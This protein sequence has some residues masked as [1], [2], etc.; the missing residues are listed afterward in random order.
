MS[1]GCG[2]HGGRCGDPCDCG[3]ARGNPCETCCS[4]SNAGTNPPG[5]DALD[6]GSS[7]YAA[8]L[9]RMRDRLS[10]ADLPAL[11][12]L[13]ARRIDEAVDPAMALVDGWA[14][15]GHVLDFYNE[16]FVNE[17]YLRTCTERRSVVE[18]ARLV[19]Y[20]P[21]PG[22]AA[23]IYL[24]FTL[25]D[26]DK[27]AVLEVPAGTRVYSQPGP[28]ETMQPFETV[29]AL[30]GRPRWSEIHPR[31]TEPQQLDLADI[32]LA[33]EDPDNEPV[34][35][36]V[37][38]ELYLKGIATGL[39]KG[40][41]LLL[42]I[43][44]LPFLEIISAIETFPGEGCTRIALRL[45]PELPDVQGDAEINDDRLEA[46]IR[47]PSINAAS[48][49]RIQVEPDELF[50]NRSY[51]AYG[52]LG[53]AYPALAANLGPA[54][55]GAT[56]GGPTG[57][58][59]VSAMRIKAAIHGHNAPQIPDVNDRGIL[60]GYREWNVRGVGAVNGPQLIEIDDIV[61]ENDDGIDDNLETWRRTIALDAVYDGIL[62][63]S[64]VV[65][66]Q[67]G[68]SL[69]RGHVAERT[70]VVERVRTVSRMQFNL[71][72]RVTV[73]TLDRAWAE[74]GPEES[75]GSFRE[76]TVY[77]QAEPVDLVE[78]PIEETVGTQEGHPWL[79]LD[80][81]YEGL[82]PGRRVIV[83]GE[84]ADLD[85]ITGVMVAELMLVARAEHGTRAQVSGQPVGNAT[86]D[87]IHTFLAFADPQLAYRYKRDTVKI[88]AN[89]AHATHGET[90]AEALGG[91]DA[92]RALQ[93]FILKQ[94][95]LTW[96]ASPT[97][98]GI[99]STLEVRVNDLLWHEASNPAAIL[100]DARQY[101][102]KTD[103]E[104]VTS[105][106]FGLGARLP[107]GHDNVRARYRTGLGQAGNIRANQASVLASR[108]NGVMGVTNPLP[109]TGGADRDGLAAIRKRTP[110]GLA[111]LDRLVSATDIEDFARA[112]AGIGKARIMPH[113]D[114][115]NREVLTIAGENDA[116]IST[117]NLRNALIAHG[118]LEGV[119]GENSV[120]TLGVPAV[121][122]E[123]RVRHALLL[124]IRARIRL[125]PDAH[126]EAVLPRLQAA[127]HEAFGF[128]AREVGQAA[129]PGLAMAVMQEVP[130]V[131]HVDLLAF[132]AIDAG[133]VDAPKTPE[134]IANQA[135]TLFQ[136]AP[137]A[138]AGLP[139]VTP[140]PA[141]FALQPDYLVFLST[142]APAT[143]LLEPIEETPQP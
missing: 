72:A 79:E 138:A 96:V 139:P 75:F 103:D 91:G 6:F 61:D 35:D 1:A 56:P 98:R 114:Q 128:D 46:L 14:C 10:G 41:A 102:A 67:P 42:E 11:R 130:G 94:K 112:F 132:G 68:D 88:F 36:L 38:R 104:T 83:T 136:V 99:A 115:P 125:L 44:D 20:A 16:R 78:R 117:G 30:S 37:T 100:P 12:A 107:T 59:T 106:T 64:Q 13:T 74:V 69:G 18:L 21:R 45:D 109:A 5:Q 81:Y 51:A 122:I 9:A 43:D 121:T 23:D 85:G 60:N 76:T 133:T 25:D 77:A 127:L 48:R 111:A 82:R 135:R 90:R 141:V 101:I 120:R 47:P 108:P 29:E 40:D 116:P 105:V 58:V 52:M 110:I 123:I 119:P 134:E 93:T 27:E 54:L 33:P 2:C 89:V 73:L 126:W 142:T 137:D 63:E 50:R 39:R 87:T 28:G 71:P 3:R 55:G 70:F 86:A 8:T 80:G 15:L 113:P 140:D 53:A 95:P 62:P 66:L 19:G 143:L 129:Q 32:D 4:P 57:N 17:H 118:N 131:A 124:G 49:D 65:I 24:A 34:L 22:V 31:L 84:R 26:V 97:A 92:A 7:R